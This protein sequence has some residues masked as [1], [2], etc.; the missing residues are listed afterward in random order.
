[1]KV[2][3]NMKANA[4]WMTPGAGY[5]WSLLVILVESGGAQF[6]HFDSVKSSGNYQ[7]AK[8]I[9]NKFSLLLEKP[10]TSPHLVDASTP[11][12]GAVY[13]NSHVL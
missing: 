3:D 1:M 7:A 13:F 10:T 12:V 2:N 4:N 8:D 11:Q 9:A 6:W 5:H